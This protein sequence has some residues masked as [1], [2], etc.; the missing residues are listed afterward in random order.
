MNKIIA[1]IFLLINLTAYTQTELEPFVNEIKLDSLRSYVYTLS[2]SKMGGRKV[3][4]EGNRIAAD[5]ITSF[6][7]KIETDSLDFKNY[8]QNFNLYRFEKGSA[9]VKFPYVNKTLGKKSDINFAYRSNF[10][11]FNDIKIKGTL[12]FEYLGFGNTIENRD[13]SDK[14]IIIL[15]EDNLKKSLDRIDSIHKKTSA[16]IFVLGLTNKGSRN[17]SP[18]KHEAENIRKDGQI[19]ALLNHITNLSSKDN[20]KNNIVFKKESDGLQ[21]DS[22]NYIIMFSD[23]YIFP[24][25]FNCKSKQLYK[26]E[27]NNTHEYAPKT[28]IVFCDIDA[29]SLRKE[30]VKSHNL[31]AYIE[32]SQKKSETIIISAHYDHLGKINDS[33][34]FFGADD[35]ASGVA[36]MMEIARIMQ[37][38]AKNGKRPKR[39]IMFVAFDAEESGMLGAE[40]FLN[41]SPIPIESIV[42]N[43]NLDMLGRERHNDDKYNKTVF[44]IA[45][46]KNSR[47]FK[48]KIHQSN[49]L[50]DSLIISKYPLP[51]S[52]ISLKKISDHY[53]FKRKGIPFV[54]FE[55]GMHKDYHTVRD[56]PD[57][58]NYE[59]L[60]KITK[61]LYKSIWEIADTDRE[62]NVK[63]KESHN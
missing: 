9:S 40:Y 55:T 17:Y 33:I 19:S 34:M 60:T 29:F 38:A 15:L 46:G 30:S 39:N 25:L 2:S 57:K 16:G 5:Y 43:I 50:S 1:I 14:V 45:D 51:F 47:F 18:K 62:L 58:I 12:E 6:F 48:D 8:R 31:I 61:V 27:K 54:Y 56:T 44:M 13:L 22:A 36:S 28:N 59:K 35:N 37:I 49:K 42:L 52:N 20:F 53:M 4:K 21:N 24:Y 41:N 7:R 11:A 63:I 26:Q 10:L 23:S 32:G 3:G